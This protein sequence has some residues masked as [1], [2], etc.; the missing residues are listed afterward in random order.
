MG[1]KAMRLNPHHPDWYR[2]NLGQAYF[3]AGDY[4]DAIATFRG[5]ANQN[6]ATRAFSAASYAL[7]GRQDEAQKEVAEALKLDPTTSLEV[8]K[9]RPFK[10][11][12]DLNRF[13]EGLRKA[14]MPERP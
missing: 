3:A 13:L 7:L 14:G 6:E 5:M 9:K 12:K 10:D 4:D 11:K 2:L 8:W 1:K